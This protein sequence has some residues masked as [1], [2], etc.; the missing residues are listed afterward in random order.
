LA[1]PIQGVFFF[2]NFKLNSLPSWHILSL[3]QARRLAP[4]IHH[5]SFKEGVLQNE[6]GDCLYASGER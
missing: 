5:V 2:L 1:P 4:H 3:L 6:V